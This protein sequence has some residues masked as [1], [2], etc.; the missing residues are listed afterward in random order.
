MSC[1][2]PHYSIRYPDLSDDS[3]SA[4]VVN[5]AVPSS[6]LEEI[7]AWKKQGATDVDVLSRLRTRCVPAGYT[8]TTWIPGV[9]TV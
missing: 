4:E 8:Y 7:V 2:I 6:L 1:Q 3:I 5:P 9:V